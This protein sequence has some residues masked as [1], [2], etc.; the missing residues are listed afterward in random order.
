MQLTLGDLKLIRDSLLRN[1]SKSDLEEAGYLDAVPTPALWKQ[2]AEID[3]EFFAR[4][5]LPHHFDLPPA[6]LHIDSYRIIQKAMSQPGRVNHAIVWPRGFGKTTTVTLAL[7]LWCICFKKRRFILIISDTYPQAKQQL[8]TLKEELETNERII[9]DFGDL[10]GNKWQEDDIQTSTRIKIQALGTG[11]KVRGRKFLQYRPDLMIVDDPENLDGVQS[12]IRRERRR[13]WF[14]RSLMKAGWWDTKVFAIGNFLHFDCLLKH[15]EENP[16]FRSKVYQAILSF[17]TRQDLWA[18]WRELI[19]DITDENKEDT[20]L[21]F[22]R[23]HRDAMMQGAISAWPEAFSYYDLMVMKVADGDAA[24]ATELQNDPIDPERRLFKTWNTYRLEW[25]ESFVPNTIGTIWLVPTTGQAAV[26]LSSCAIFAATDPSMGTTSTSD[27]SAIVLIAKAPTGLMFILEADIKRRPPD[28][29]I[30]AQIHFAKKYPITRWRIESNA[31]QAMYSTESA[32]RSAEEGVYLPIEPY[33]QLA[34]KKLRI[35]SLQPDLENGY[36]LIREDGQEELKHELR[37][38]PMGADEHGL[39]ALEAVRTL[40][41]GWE[42]T[43]GAEMVQAE[44]H[45]YGPKS[46]SKQITQAQAQAPDPYAKWDELADTT[47]YRMK[48]ASARAVAIAEG[49]DPDAA[50]DEIPV[51]EKIFVPMMFV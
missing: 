20:A 32:K 24:F 12:A 16:M 40:A 1:F 22:F 13:N 10:Q 44:I 18:D 17:A 47:L 35:N 43:S 42:Q 6:P 21:A 3:L 19:T 48:V 4:F 46:L 38:W 45:T 49:R 28:Q 30:N 26:P 29:I 5:Y 50:E 33:N 39:D 9:E 7:P 41:K 27:K 31:F 14:F 11:M 25:R 37:E 36:L 51:P 15:L 2:L 23:K 34:N 8:A